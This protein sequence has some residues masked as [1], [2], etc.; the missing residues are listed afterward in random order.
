MTSLGYPSWFVG[1]A[2]P[3]GSVLFVVRA[4]EAW[5]R[6]R[7]GRRRRARHARHL[8]DGSARPAPPVRLLRRSSCS[9]N[10]P[11]AAALGISSVLAIAV[12]DLAPLELIP[13][14]LLSATDSWT[15]LAVP[16]FILAGNLLAKT[17][18]SERLI[19]LAT[20]GGRAAPRRARDGRGDRLHLLRRHLRLRPRRHGGAGGDPHPGDGD[21]GVRPALRGRAHGGGR[22]HRHHHPAVDRPR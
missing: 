2:V 12:F 6:H 16:F 7:R 10:F 4:V 9:S 8:T 21:G 13:Q 11:I 22:R 19:R 18:I 20:G 1:L 3:V 17:A 14:Q 5:W 15:L